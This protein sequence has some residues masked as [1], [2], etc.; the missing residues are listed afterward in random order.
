MTTDSLPA[1]LTMVAVFGSVAF[2]V[3]W[4]RLSSRLPIPEVLRMLATPFCTAC[5]GLFLGFPLSFLFFGGKIRNSPHDS[6]IAATAATCFAAG[7]ALGVPAIVGWVL[8]Y[9]QPR[10]DP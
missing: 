3:A 10:R 7:L 6:V 9:R 4:G 8:G 1:A 5:L 2:G